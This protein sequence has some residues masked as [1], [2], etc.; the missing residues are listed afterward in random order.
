MRKSGLQK[1]IASIFDDVPVPETDPKSMQAADTQ[2][3]ENDANPGPP[4]EDWDFAAGL[5][6]TAA[7]SFVGTANGRCT[8]D[9][10]AYACRFHP[11]SETAA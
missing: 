8:G 7:A 3:A 4:Q 5:Q 1:Q 11:A 2:Q 6:L 10:C 9:K